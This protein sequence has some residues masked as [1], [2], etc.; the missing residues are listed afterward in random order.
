[1]KTFA[2]SVKVHSNLLKQDC[3]L[4]YYVPDEVDVVHST[5]KKFVNLTEVPDEDGLKVVATEENYPITPEYVSS[6]AAS[7]DYRL[8]PQSNINRA[9]VRSNLGD[10]RTYQEASKTDSAVLGA[11]FEA[12]Y[13]A[14]QEARQKAVQ[15]AQTASA[16]ISNQG[17][18]SK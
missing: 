10:V 17:G 16:P 8:D 11:R 12:M 7:T 14:Y 6:F 13:Q 2:R 4:R 18:E 5:P 9:G 3:Y 1:M 15:T